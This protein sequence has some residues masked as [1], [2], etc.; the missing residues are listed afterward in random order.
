MRIFKIVKL[1]FTELSHSCVYRWHPS[2]F[3]IYDTWNTSYTQY[4]ILFW[5]HFITVLVSSAKYHKQGGLSNKYLF[6]TV[7]E[8]GSWRW[9]AT[10]SG[11][12]EDPLLTLQTAYFSLYPYKVER[13]STLV[14]S[15]PKKNTN[16]I[17]EGSTQLTELSPQS[18]T[19]KYH[20]IGY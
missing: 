20:H 15:L 2:I 9:G 8:A 7:L 3:F 13:E 5:G 11:S 4:N 14:P 12:G 16:P 10:Q 18:P 17:Y 1:D 19:S 6:L